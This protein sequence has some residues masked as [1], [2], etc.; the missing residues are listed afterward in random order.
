MAVKFWEHIKGYTKFSLKN[1]LIHSFLYSFIY[2][3]FRSFTCL[4]FSG[5]NLVGK[6]TQSVR[7]IVQ[8]VKEEG[9]PG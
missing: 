5:S 9:V 4:L 7:R 3:F 1:L 6:F 2:L 8:E